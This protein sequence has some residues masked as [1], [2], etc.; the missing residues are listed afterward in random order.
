MKQP[1][2]LQQ[3][4]SEIAALLPYTHIHPP[5]TQHLNNLIS[6]TSTHPNLHSILTSRFFNTLPI[7]V[8]A[9][10]LL[11]SPFTLPPEW[12]ENLARLARPELEEEDRFGLGGGKGGV[13]GWARKAGEE[14]NLSELGKGGQEWFVGPENVRG[15]WISAIRHR[16]KWRELSESV[17]WIMKSNAAGLLEDKEMSEKQR[18]RKAAKRRRKVDEILDDMLELV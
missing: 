6:A 3:Y 10:R 17:M 8:K 15:I 4:V 5:L 1:A 14:P 12:Q 13:D 9:H 7:L 11:S 2:D 18:N 16:V